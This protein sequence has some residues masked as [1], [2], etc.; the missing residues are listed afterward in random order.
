MNAPN[1]KEI[2]NLIPLYLDNILDNEENLLVEEHIKNCPA[3]QK[4]L[5]F[6]SAVMAKTKEL[7]EIS[8][9][10]GMRQKIIEKAK[11]LNA[12]K[13]IKRALYLKR[14]SSGVAV[15]AV[16]AI[17]VVGFNGL[18][19]PDTTIDE[20]SLSSHTEIA[21]NE[22]PSPEVSEKASA[23]PRKIEAVTP[24]PPKKDTSLTKDTPSRVPPLADEP[25]VTEDAE[26]TTNPSVPSL[27]SEVDLEYFTKAT[28]E[29]TAENE[30]IV[31]ELITDYEKDDTGY[32]IHDMNI[33]LRKLKD[34]GVKVKTEVSADIT[35]DYLVLE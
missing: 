29:I 11:E 14:I 25:I 26:N 24:E 7:P 2:L 19:K 16:V 6:M 17:S 21:E 28:I 30:A 1:C 8:V 22:I 35:Q 10:S 32:I 18:N 34:S 33:L 31:T 20:I 12:Q 13:R 9:P 5:D 27:F 3:C 23:T 15:A 4:E